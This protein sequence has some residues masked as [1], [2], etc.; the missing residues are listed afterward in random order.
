[1][2]NTIFT[3]R[4]KTMK[5]TTALVAII[6]M[7]VM[8]ASIIPAQAYSIIGD[9]PIADYDKYGYYVY[10]D[11]DN[12]NGTTHLNYFGK[13]GSKNALDLLCDPFGFTIQGTGHS[14]GTAEILTD[15]QGNKY[16][17][18]TT[19]GS[20]DYNALAVFK[21]QGSN[22]KSYVLGEATEVSFSFRVGDITDPKVTDDNRISLIITRRGTKKGNTGVVTADKYGNIYANING[23]TKMIYQNADGKTV[24]GDGEFIDF[25]FRWYDVSNTYSV[26]I[27]GDPVVQAMPLPY[28]YRSTDYVAHSFDDDFALADRVVVGS[29]GNPDSTGAANEDRTIEVLRYDYF[30]S[31]DLPAEQKTGYKFIYDVDDVKLSRIESAQGGA[32]YYDNSFDGLYEGFSLRSTKSD[33]YLYASGYSSSNIKLGKEGDNTYLELASGQYFSLNDKHYQQYLQGNMVIEFS[34]NAKPTHTSGKKAIVRLNDTMCMNMPKLL[35]VDSDGVL[36]ATNEDKT[37]IDGYK[38]DGKEWLDIA[39]VVIKNHDN[40][41]NFGTFNA[42]RNESSKND[43]FYFSFYINGNYVGTY[44]QVLKRWNNSAYNNPQ[45]TTSGH[46]YT[47]ADYTVGGDVAALDLAALTLVDNA[48]ATNHKIYKSADGGTYYDI[49]FDADGNQT[50][51]STMVIDSALS[52]DDENIRIF[53]DG[54]ME[55]KLDNIRIYEGSAPNSAYASANSEKGGKVLGVE[56][57]STSFPT[58]GITASSRAEGSDVYG[59][60][61]TAGVSANNVVHKTANGEVPVITKD[62][63]GNVTKDTIRDSEY[64]TI[65]VN[66]GCWFDYFVPMPTK[67]NGVYD[68][69]YRFEATIKN[70]GFKA[71]DSGVP[72]WINLFSHRFEK[73]GFEKS[74]A[75]SILAIDKNFNIYGGVDTIKLYNADGTEAKFDNSNWSTFACDL[76]YYQDGTTTRITLSY[77]LNGELLYLKDG[78]PAADMVS[79]VIGSGMLDRFGTDNYRVRFTQMASGKT[80]T[81]DVKSFDITA[82]PKAVY[83]EVSFNGVAL[84]D[85]V[86]SI[87]ITLPKNTSSLV[88]GSYD[89]LSIEKTVGGAK[90]T[91]PLLK[92][93]PNSGNVLVGVAGQF[94]E[95][96][97]ASGNAY[98]VGDSGLPVAIVYDDINGMARYYVDGAVAFI[99]LNGEKTVAVDLTTYSYTFTQLASV[100]SA[101]L[102][103]FGGYASDEVILDKEA[104]GLTAYNLKNSDAAEIVGFQVNSITDGIRILAGTDS[105]Y[106]SNVGIE[107]ET[108]VGGVSKGTK[109]LSI[110]TVY[111]SVV[112]A[113]KVLNAEDVGY[114][115][116]AAC[117]INK[118]PASFEDNTYIN[119]RAYS[120][121]CGY[122]H[123]DTAIRLVITNEGYYFVRDGVLYENDFNGLTSLP[124]TFTKSG[125]ST[126]TIAPAKNS[127]LDFK[128]TASS[129]SFYYLN[130]YVGNNYHIQADFTPTGN[131]SNRYFGLVARYTSLT[132]FVIAGTRLNGEGWIEARV[133]SSGWNT[134]V[135]FNLKDFGI[136]L[137]RGKTYTYSLICEDDYIA[138]F[139]DGMLIA[140]G[141]IPAGYEK[142][143]PGVAASG[144][145]YELDNFIVRQNKHSTY[146]GTV[147]ENNFDGLTALPTDWKTSFAGDATVSVADGKV[148]L[149]ESTGAR[150]FVYLNKSIGEEYTFEADLTVNSY[151]SGA[152]RNEL[153]ILFGAEGPDKF[154]YAY[155]L[156]GGYGKLQ[157]YD[158]SRSPQ[159]QNTASNSEYNMSYQAGKTYKVKLVC[160]GSNTVSFY[161][162]GT[163]MKTGTF[164]GGYSKTGAIGFSFQGMN[165]TFDNVKVTGEMTGFKKDFVLYEENFDS[166]TEVPA[167][168]D[169]N[170]AATR[171]SNVSGFT[172]SMSDG[173]L[174]L[175]SSNSGNAVELKRDFE[176]TNY[177][178][179]ADI[180]FVGSGDIRGGLLFGLHEDQGKHAYAIIRLSGTSADLSVFTNNG[181]S[182]KF[183]TIGST[184]LSA[185]PSAD[186]KHRLKL[187]VNDG[188]VTFIVNGVKL[189]TWEPA[190]KDC[191]SGRFGIFFRQGTIKVDNVKLTKPIELYSVNQN[192]GS[193][194]RIR[195]ATFNIGDFS[196]ASGSSGDGIAKGNGTAATQ[197]DYRAVFEKVGAD[198]WGLQEDSQYFNGTQQNSPYDAVYSVVHT[199]YERNFTGAYNGKA[200][201]TSYEIYDVKPVYYQMRTLDQ[202]QMTGYS[203]PWFLTGKIMVDGKEIAIATLHFDWSCKEMRAHQIDQ[204]IEWAKQHT[205]SIIIGDVNPDDCIGIPSQK[206]DGTWQSHTALSEES[207][208]LVDNKRFTDA[209]FVP[210]NGGR[211]GT[212]YTIMKNGVPRSES[213]CDNIYVSPNIRIINAEAVYEPWMNDHAIVVADIEIN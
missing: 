88:K 123:Y 207:T 108:F 76:H 170:K 87:D 59:T 96:V 65:T 193:A 78:T 206:S 169:I 173:Q 132:S 116:L 35:Y 19:K 52:A 213:P 7:L 114:K 184:N 42:S 99:N 145:S 60:F 209:G 194:T 48:P 46:K 98:T 168:W 34:V 113:D 26:Y 80:I 47:L 49:T 1:M 45:F 83:N 200:F 179:E 101:K 205:Y 187:V 25:I 106:Y 93:E 67:V 167:E 112:A 118:L 10:Y 141:T 27:N 147:Y 151:I 197:A 64:A 163:L 180:T 165:V 103:L 178:Y 29:T 43:T 127:V 50:A 97:D 12:M 154:G 51:Y 121:I 14:D 109:T 124:A 16:L 133:G 28:N 164:S 102:V 38:L 30:D 71:G 212:F 140:E 23:S 100:S 156:K 188:T 150:S 24:G 155:A 171:F 181:D 199:N 81:M 146:E 191:L 198:L 79:S 211:F 90:Q 125:E 22:G 32:V 172:K 89:A 192:S 54:S 95:L 131:D 63:K 107:M 74:S 190:D 61:I 44:S 208:H 149:N 94:Y 189:G 18:Y 185:K 210:A 135:K 195:V 144:M 39:I 9:E 120:E 58:G 130:Q 182:G 56:F 15:G 176:Y 104:Y 201:L 166:Y 20:R 122:K 66:P 175:S 2:E 203:H 134:F 137:E 110:D 126:S 21:M 159:W 82:M 57:G 31:N 160:T 139:I 117:I 70:V 40:D 115:Y 186:V 177:V 91:M 77:Y 72:T 36:Y 111:S 69:E 204:V 153:G 152:S 84:N 148:T 157:T 17:H 202:S 33:V 119:L 161:V 138:L 136:T 162:D 86:T 8:I 143:A 73:D 129:L 11:F 55:A 41:G 128:S 37:R 68:F 174:M 142:G 5:K 158:K 75:N 13:A 4:L 53:T 105:L 62:D 85:R 3:R 92:V 6:L 183:D 196:T